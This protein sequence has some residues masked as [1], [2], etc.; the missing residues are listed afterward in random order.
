M[1]SYIKVYKE[2]IFYKYVCFNYY[3]HDNFKAPVV[4]MPQL[5][6]EYRDNGV[7]QVYIEFQVWKQKS[8]L[9]S[10]ASF[11]RQFSARNIILA[12]G[13]QCLFFIDI[14]IVTAEK[15]ESYIKFKQN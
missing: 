13:S 14:C 12:I 5:I 6:Q 1:L 3:F 11:T 15:S 7:L 8:L 4:T 10:L 9:M 2:S